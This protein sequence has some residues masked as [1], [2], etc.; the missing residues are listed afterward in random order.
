MEVVQP[1]RKPIDA[2]FVQAPGGDVNSGL[3]RFKHTWSQHTKRKL[4]SSC[5][6]CHMIIAT[7]KDEM[8]L[9]ATEHKHR[10]ESLPSNE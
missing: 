7:A 9:L 4:D 6:R 2:A 1:I 8:T 5:L 10:C 3:P